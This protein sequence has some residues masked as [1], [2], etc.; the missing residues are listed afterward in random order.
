MNLSKEDLYEIKR[1]LLIAGTYGISDERKVN[2]IVEK[3]YEIEEGYDETSKETE[4]SNEKTS[5]VQ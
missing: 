3:I 1:V 5:D 4:C 2:S